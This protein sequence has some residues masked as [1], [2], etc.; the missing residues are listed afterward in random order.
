MSA[1][2]PPSGRA[3]RSEVRTLSSA[4]EPNAAGSSKPMRQ[5]SFSGRPRRLSEGG[6][7]SATGVRSVNRI[8]GN[9]NLSINQTP[10]AGMMGLYIGQAQGELEALQKEAE[11]EVNKERKKLKN[12]ESRGKTPLNNINK[13][14]SRVKKAENKLTEVKSAIE[15]VMES[16]RPKRGRNNNAK[17]SS[18]KR[19]NRGNKPPKINTQPRNNVPKP[20]ASRPTSFLSQLKRTT[21]AIKRKETIVETQAPS[22]TTTTSTQRSPPKTYVVANVAKEFMNRSLVSK[23]E[24]E[25]VNQ[26]RPPSNKF[27]ALTT[28]KNP[29][30]TIVLPKSLNTPTAVSSSSSEGV[31]VATIRTRSRVF[32]PNG[33]VKEQVSILRRRFESVFDGV[34]GDGK[35]IKLNTSDYQKQLNKLQTSIESLHNKINRK[36]MENN[37]LA[38]YKKNL[39]A[40]LNDVSK[41]KLVIAKRSSP[42]TNTSTQTSA[43][44]PATIRP[45]VTNKSVNKI[46]KAITERNAKVPT[47]PPG[48]TKTNIERLLQP[49]KQPV[50]V[51]VAPTISVKGGSA[52]ATGGSLQQTQIQYKTPANKK[53]K[54]LKLIRSPETM[55]KEKSAAFRKEIISKLRSPAATKRREAL[56]SLR[57][58]TVGQ[59]KKHVIQ[60]I[61]R[62]LHRMK[63]PKDAEK[64]LIKFYE[65]LSEKQIKS[66]FGGRSP[67]FVKITLKKQID[68]LKKKKR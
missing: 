56:Y 39:N 7:T 30:K 55:R 50:T 18:N 20:T 61:D 10:V 14:K 8:A 67:E 53:K 62:V 29:S 3:S 16:K 41:L 65:G 15:K 59:R 5:N 28:V 21:G 44:K 32:N 60:L 43:P 34:I 11:D 52:K 2:L 36:K 19:T 23:A 12:M 25:L 22:K 13:Q 9:L 4:S 64:K 40:L 17:E 49:F 6:Q 33:K 58:P 66:L 1:S 42:K 37:S 51:T 26:T 54:P 24:R 48:I 57:T 68:Y 31:P 38:V 46:L 35:T 45:L 47:T 27:K 63:A